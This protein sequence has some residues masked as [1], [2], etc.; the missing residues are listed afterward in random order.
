MSKFRLAVMSSAVMVLAPWPVAAAEYVFAVP[1]DVRS[2][3]SSVRTGLVSCVV[4]DAGGRAIGAAG[5]QTFTLSSGSYRG[6]VE[7]RVTTPA[8]AT[9]ASWLCNLRFMLP[10][11]SAIDFG[12]DDLSD[13]GGRYFREEFRR[14]PGAEFRYRIEGRF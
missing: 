4:I 13:V 2:L 5:R 1:V 7:V 11:T 12:A 8:G 9:A 14:A 10:P 6:D 3:H